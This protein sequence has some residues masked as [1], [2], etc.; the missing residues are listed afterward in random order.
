MKVSQRET[1][2]ELNVLLHHEKL[3]YNHF[4]L[5]APPP[6]LSLFISISIFLP[7]DMTFISYQRIKQNV[8]F[9]LE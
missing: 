7:Q 9:T 5:S 8:L 2:Y 6:S 4:L 1:V 3:C